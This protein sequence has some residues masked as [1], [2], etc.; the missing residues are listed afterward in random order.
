[1][2]LYSPNLCYHWESAPIRAQAC[3]TLTAPPQSVLSLG[4]RANPRPSLHDPYNPNVCYHWESAPIRAKACRTL[5]ALI[6]VHIGNPRQSAPRPAGSSQ[7]Q[8]A[9]RSAGSLQPQCVLLLRNRA[10]PRPGL[11]DP[12]SPNSCYHWESAPIHAQA[13]RIPTTPMCA[14]TGNPHQSAPRSAGS[15][16]PQCVLLLAICANPRPGLQDPYNPK[17]CSHWEIAPIRAQACRTLTAPNCAHTGNPRQ[18]APRCV[19]ST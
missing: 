12:Y 1:M 2:Q 13:C 11:Q 7:P 6:C 4:I 14:H 10:N 3:R 16:E 15:L 9:P 5:T 8:S 17:L 18:S 19:M